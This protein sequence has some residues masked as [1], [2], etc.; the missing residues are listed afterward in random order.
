MPTEFSL[1]RRELIERLCILIGASAV[2]PQAIA[3]QAPVAGRRRYLGHADF[4]LLSAVADTIIPV[5]DTPGALAA[6]VPD[7]FAA[8]LTRW[9]SP[10]R[11]VQLLRAMRA[12]DRRARA[13]EGQ[14]FAALSADRRFSLLDRHDKSALELITPEGDGTGP[15]ASAGPFDGPR[16]RDAGYAKLK[17][18]IVVLFYLSEVALTRELRYEHAP[19]PWQP[20]LPLTPDYRPDG[21][22]NLI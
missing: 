20:S 14:A 11:R 2:A 17:E 4:R 19:G 1:N 15:A 18:L 13:E 12:I 22:P 9:A 7:R 6:G 21:S 5:T 16:V 3:L 10:A 8:L